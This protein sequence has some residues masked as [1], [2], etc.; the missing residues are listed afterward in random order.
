MSGRDAAESFGDLP[1]QLHDI[2]RVAGLEAAMQLVR[3]HGGTELWV[4]RY[5]E[6]GGLLTAS[7]GR[8]AAER[9]CAHYRVI[10]ADGH[11]RGGVRIYVPQC[12]RGVLAAARRRLAEDL[13]AGEMSVRAAAKRAGLSERAAYRLLAKLNDPRQGSLF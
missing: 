13:Q 8:E 9:I 5:A 12:G 2:A 11:V 3:D 6:E 4:P 7:V 1:A 10:D